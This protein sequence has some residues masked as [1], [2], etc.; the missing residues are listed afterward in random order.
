MTEQHT[1]AARLWLDDQPLRPDWVGPRSTRPI[2]VVLA[3]VVCLALIGGGLFASGG[4]DERTDDQITVAPGE[5][6]E[7]GPFQLIFTDAK[8]WETQYG[9]SPRSGWKVRVYGFGRTTGDKSDQ[10]SSP[11]TAIGVDGSGIAERGSVSRVGQFRS[12][13]T[14]FQP[15]MP[16][17]PIELDVDLPPEFEP[18]DFI[19]L[20]VGRLVTQNN[21]NTGDPS[22]EVLRLG[23]KWYQLRLP[24]TRET[25]RPPR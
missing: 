18:E 2:W 13:G 17:A 6:F 10:L 15:G 7:T 3:I 4:L 1:P 5:L 25:G 9:T 8:I 20:I 14:E 12:F 16:M 11:W 21:S 19:D 22:G 23:R 24:M